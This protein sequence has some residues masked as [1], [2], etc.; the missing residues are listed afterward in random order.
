MELERDY[1]G[2]FAKLN[3]GAP[4][5]EVLISLIGMHLPPGFDLDELKVVRM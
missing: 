1:S 5:Q 4:E 3:G 2:W